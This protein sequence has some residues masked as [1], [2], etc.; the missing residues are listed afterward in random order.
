VNNQSV[1]FQIAY[2]FKEVSDLWKTI[3]PDDI[4]WSQHFYNVIE[5]EKPSDIESIYCIVWR[6]DMP[7][8]LIYGQYKMVKLSESI[9]LK[10]ES[11]TNK[12]IKKILLPRLKQDTLIIGNL[13]L[14]G[15]YGMHFPNIEQKE[16]FQILEEGIHSIRKDLKTNKHITIGP[17]LIKDFF[18]TDVDK[19]QSILGATKFKVQPNMIFEIDRSWSKNSDYVAA[20]KAKARTR[21]NKAREKAQSIVVKELSL[22]DLTALKQTMNSLYMNIATNASFN[23]FYL[24]QDYFFTMKA[25][26]NNA[27]KLFGYYENE[28]LKGFITMI[29]NGD[30]LDAHFLGYDPETNHHAQLYLNMLFDMIDQGIMLNKKKLIFSRTAMEIKS[31]AGAKPHD[32]YCFLLHLNPILNS[33]TPRVINIVYKEVIWEERNPFK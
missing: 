30:H 28:D 27:I 9:R 12:L 10:T 11:W 26:L 25:K 3:A 16:S 31:S 21:Y 19:I 33:I 4:F 20:L 29:E 22:S 18:E 23:M 2:S 24:G 6:S 7:I 14:T 17:V 1:T 32:M 5:Q 13:L 8:G 15:K